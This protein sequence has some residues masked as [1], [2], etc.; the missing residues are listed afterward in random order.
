[1]AGAFQASAFQRN[2]FQCGF[3]GGGDKHRLPTNIPP[4]YYEEKKRRP[5]Q[6]IWDRVKQQKAEELRRARTPTPSPPKAEP[7]P[8]DIFGTIAPAARHFP[9]IGTNDDVSRI[10]LQMA[11]ARDL[12]DVLAAL[13]TVGPNSDRV[14]DSRDIAD[15]ADAIR[16][17]Q[18]VLDL[19]DISTAFASLG[20]QQ[21]SQPDDHQDMTDIAEVF[22]HLS[23]LTH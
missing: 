5:V 6:P 12:A 15:L 19:A 8:A 10:A 1:M 18:D 21:Q 20:P 2:A 3:G 17:I 7:P 4:P 9:D 16:Q 22:G 13:S 11:D 14:D 23:T